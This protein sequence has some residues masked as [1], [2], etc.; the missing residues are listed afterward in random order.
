MRPLVANNPDALMLSFAEAFRASLNKPAQRRGDY[1]YR[2]MLAGRVWRLVQAT[3]KVADN[4][5]AVWQEWQTLACVP[6]E[7][8][9]SMRGAGA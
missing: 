2:A 9:S 4:R 1:Q 8:R 5:E 3:Y 7:A 6:S